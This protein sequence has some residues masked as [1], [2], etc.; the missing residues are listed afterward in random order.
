MLYLRPKEVSSDRTAPPVIGTL[1]YTEVQDMLAI[2][3]LL[4]QQ[5]R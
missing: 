5:T 2:I 4:S 1:N 3:R